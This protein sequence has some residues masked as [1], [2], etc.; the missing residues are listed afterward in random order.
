MC[1]YFLYRDFIADHLEDEEDDNGGA[2]RWD[3]CSNISP[4]S[5]ECKYLAFFTGLFNISIIDCSFYF[6]TCF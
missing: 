3:D 6:K 2:S 5:V 4:T 1:H